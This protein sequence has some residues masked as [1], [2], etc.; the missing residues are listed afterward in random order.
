LTNARRAAAGEGAPRLLAGGAMIATCISFI[1]TGFIVATLNPPMLRLVLVPLVAATLVAGAGACILAFHAQKPKAVGGD[2]RLRNPFEF[3][4]VVMFAA[5]LGLLV[6]ASRAITEQFGAAGA[7]VAA[8]VTG[9]GDIDAVAVSMTKLAPATLDLD[10]AAFA[11]LAA[12]L[13]NNVSK[14]AMGATIGGRAFAVAVGLATA[15]AL[16]AGALAWLIAVPLLG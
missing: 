5:L 9:L 4:P 14:V 15:A 3:R 12:V 11:V 8:L 13:S 16:L 6:L 2:D 10:H 7:T 1:R